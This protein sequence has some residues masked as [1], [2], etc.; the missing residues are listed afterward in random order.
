VKNYKHETIQFTI[1]VIG[2]LNGGDIENKGTGVSRTLG[3]TK[4]EKRDSAL[5]CWDFV[6]F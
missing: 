6:L 3:L 5:V 1:N 2:N 4:I